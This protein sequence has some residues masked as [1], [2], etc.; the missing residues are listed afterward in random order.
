MSKQSQGGNTRT[1][2]SLECQ[3]GL[4]KESALKKNT[5]FAHGGRKLVQKKNLKLQKQSKS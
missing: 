5:K 4:V 2:A 1:K 3:S